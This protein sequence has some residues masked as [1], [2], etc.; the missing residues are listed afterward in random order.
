MLSTPLTSFGIEQGALK[1]FDSYRSDRQQKCLVNG[2]VSD[3][4]AVTCGL[5]QRS[6]IGTLLFL[7]Y[8]NDLPNCLSKALPRMYVDD[9]SISIA[10]RSLPELESALNTELA[11][12]HKCLNVNKLSLNIAK[13]EL[14]LIAHVRDL[15]LQ[16][17][18][19]LLY[20]EIDR[21]PHTKSLAV[22]KFLSF[23]FAGPHLRMLNTV[24]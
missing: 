12:L 10:A 3:A 13:T 19:H 21:V 15:L 16:L 22:Y 4:R 7:I 5:P 17:A 11:N 9:T 6:L 14:M 8:V 2:E 1:W 24:T 18:I 20:N 23:S